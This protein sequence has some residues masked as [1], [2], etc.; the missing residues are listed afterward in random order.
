MNK[1]MSYFAFLMLG[2]SR[3]YMW[4]IVVRIAKK[5]SNIRKK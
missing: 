4:V 1:I 2:V 3:I 5:D